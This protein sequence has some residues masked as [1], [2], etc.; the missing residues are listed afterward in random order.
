MS[1][2]DLQVPPEFVGGPEPWE[3]ALS[4][5]VENLVICQLSE[6]TTA[7]ELLA[8][9]DTLESFPI[10]CPE[11]F[12]YCACTE[13]LSATRKYSDAG[14]HIALIDGVFGLLRAEGLKRDPDGPDDVFTFMNTFV[15]PTLRQL[16][17]A[18]PVPPGYKHNEVASVLEQDPEYVKGDSFQADLA[19]YARK[20][21]R[22]LR[23]WSLVGRLDAD[24]LL[25]S[26]AP[27]VGA[28]PLLLHQGS[29]L[30]R[31]L[32][33]PVNRGVWETLWE[34]ALRC[35][36][37]MAYGQWGS[38]N[39]ERPAEFEDAARRIAGDERVSLLW[40]GR[41][42]IMLEGLEKERK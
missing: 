31:A 11:V 6:E 26:D 40:R 28:M 30:L 29:R 25:G 42:A 23:F 37:D 4:N 33:D 16:A 5:F 27:G 10:P 14:E 7:Q 22:Q 39:L 17:H 35:D 13:L 38:H 15:A 8:L 19:E 12:Y 1:A 36:E 21:E 2:L 9:F 32:E 18:I 3:T 41:F 34:A 24:G 20:H